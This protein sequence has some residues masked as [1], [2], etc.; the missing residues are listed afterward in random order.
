MTRGAK[1]NED[2]RIPKSGSGE[3]EGRRA[4]EDEKGE[5]NK[6]RQRGKTRA[7]SMKTI[8]KLH[9]LTRLRNH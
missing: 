8:Q 5:G 2:G 4:G 6:E 9:N 3:E 7:A 1:D